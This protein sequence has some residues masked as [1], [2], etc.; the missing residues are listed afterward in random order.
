MPVSS[1]VSFQLF[2]R[3]VIRRLQGRTD[4]DRPSVTAR[5][6]EPVSAP[7]HKRTFIRVTLSRGADGW[8]ATPTGHQGSHVLSSISRADGLA[9]IPEAVTDAQVG[10]PV[11]VLLL[12]DA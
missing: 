8:E 12:V 11:S 9:V 4:L 1:F 2:V 6:T 10:M 7:P 5:L 3:P